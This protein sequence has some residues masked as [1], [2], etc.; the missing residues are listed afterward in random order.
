MKFNQTFGVCLYLVLFCSVVFGQVDPASPPN[1][2]V[3][4]CVAKYFRPILFRDSVDAKGEATYSRCIKPSTQLCDITWGIREGNYEGV[5]CLVEAGFDFNVRN[6]TSTHY[7]FPLR[8]AA[9]RD[10]EMLK[11]LFKS[12]IPIDVDQEDSTGDTTLL[13]IN[14]SFFATRGFTRGHSKFGADAAYKVLEFLLQKGANPN[15]S[16]EGKTSLMFQVAADSQP[17]FIALLLQYGADPNLRSKQGETALMAAID[18]PAK[19]QLLLDAGANIY[20]KDNYGKS[21]IFHAIEKCHVNKLS[22]LLEK[23]PDILR[24]ES[25]EGTT[26]LEY[27]KKQ[28]SSTNCRQF[29]RFENH[30]TRSR[31]D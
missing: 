20:V 29:K 1:E 14:A 27:L 10:V 13:S 31:G 7:Y 28:S 25:I 21:A 11:L 30:L 19:V 26:A 22:A 2:K 5:R 8:S 18:D 3:G 24:S 15:A 17:K 23:D 9:F 12:K 6:W 16:R 4:T